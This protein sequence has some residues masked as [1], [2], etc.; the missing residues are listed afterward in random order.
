[1]K[2][3][4]SLLLKLIIQSFLSHSNAGEYQVEHRVCS[5]EAPYEGEIIYGMKLNTRKKICR[6]F[7]I[8]ENVVSFYHQC[9]DMCLRDRKCKS[10]SFEK[11]KNERRPAAHCYKLKARTA[12]LHRIRHCFREQEDEINYIRVDLDE[13][14][15]SQLSKT[16]DC[17]TV[18]LL[19]E[20]SLQLNQLDK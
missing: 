9:F 3:E 2:Y 17:G 6:S 10:F 20:Q 19:Q 7:I 11:V 15:R 16:L 1:M 14:V 13:Y 5:L 4:F 18:S 8:S 12:D